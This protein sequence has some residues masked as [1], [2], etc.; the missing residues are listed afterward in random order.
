MQK[1]G[2]SEQIR[3]HLCCPTCRSRLNF[4]SDAVLCTNPRCR[5]RYPVIEGVPVL[6]NESNSVFSLEDFTLGRDTT[7]HLKRSTTKTLLLGLL[8]RL[9]N[10]SA[11]IGTSRH[12]V[13]LRDLLLGETP[14]PKVLV[15]GGSILG[16]GMEALTTSGSLELVATDVS[17][18]PLTALVCDAHDIPF[19]DETFDG[20]IVQ[21]VLEHVVD[22]YRCVEEIYRVLKQRGLV[23]A[24]TPFMQQV[25]MG[26]FD[27][28]R[29]TH[30]G[31]RR[32]FRHFD[33][34]ASGSVAG[35]GMALAWSY[36]YFLLSFTMSRPLR[37]VLRAFARL[38][39]FYLKYFDYYLVG[40]S[41][42][43]DAA[44]GFYFLGRKSQ[45]TLPDRAL[46][47][48]YKGALSN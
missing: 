35:P 44:S 12:Y 39:S 13:R 34:V 7:F 40:K 32:V 31:H 4:T 15:I 30:S 19:E 42:T 45:M 20:V 10:I 28:T 18:G 8:D 11:S 29:F 17:F 24:E 41:A 16:Q 2:L 37:G 23:Y 27:F 47:Q 46:I 3:A 43:I 25:H 6:I 22:P 21:A 48:Y 1:L 38:T 14:A 26:R 5:V 33:E 36:E 9:P